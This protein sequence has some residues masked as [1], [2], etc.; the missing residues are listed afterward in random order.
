MSS[1]QFHKVIP[2]LNTILKI[3]QL[4]QH[5]VQRKTA[6]NSLTVIFFIITMEQVN[7]QIC[8]DPYWE[9]CL[10]N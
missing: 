9:D 10:Q 2:L 3:I 8:F 1:S 4:L 6:R 7:Y 5:D